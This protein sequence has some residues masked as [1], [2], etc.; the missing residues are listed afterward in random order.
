EPRELLAAVYDAYSGNL[1]RYALMLLVD[2]GAAEDALHEAFA[3]L[4]GMGRRMGKIHSYQG[5]LR[6]A[7]RNECYRIIQR[8]QRRGKEIDV[9]S[10][11]S[12]LES[13]G[14]EGFDEEERAAVELAIRSL[15]ADQ[16]EIIY[17]KVYEQ[18]T[19]QR[20][21]E[22]LDISINT[23]ASRY[24]YAMDK[25]RRLLAGKMKT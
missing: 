17:L 21:A 1:Y 8:R 13:T 19:F 5:Y 12:I 10:V 15:P 20:I 6:R 18:M 23:V 4:A 22:M 7:V 9:A 11:D 3:K 25:L 24:R 2:H 14:S 16:R